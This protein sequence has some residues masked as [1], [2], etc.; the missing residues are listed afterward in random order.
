ML[1]CIYIYIS[2][3][4]LDMAPSPLAKSPDPAEG[5][6]SEAESGRSG[7]R[8]S[9]PDK[10]HQNR[11]LGIREAFSKRPSGRVDGSSN[12]I[13][14]IENLELMAMGMLLKEQPLIPSTSED[15][16]SKVY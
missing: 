11:R 5:K 3:K 9:E 8:E 6:W 14:S 7:E 4:A 13:E 16:V 15:S 1:G 10:V 12:R 2:P